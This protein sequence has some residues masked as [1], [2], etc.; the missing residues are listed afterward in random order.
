MNTVIIVVMLLLLFLKITNMLL[1]CEETEDIE[2]MGF[3]AKNRQV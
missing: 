3:W 1:G 2:Q